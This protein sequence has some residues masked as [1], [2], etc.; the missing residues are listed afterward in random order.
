MSE[1]APHPTTPHDHARALGALGLRVLPIKPG[2]KRP[3]MSSWQHAA[4][5]DADKIDNWY[6]GLYRDA[7]VGIALG[8]QPNGLY[9]FAI[10][11]DTHDPAHNGWDALADLEEEHGELPATWRSL[12]GADGA[13]LIFAAPAGVTVRN[14]QASGNRIAPGIDVRGDGGQIVV[15][16]TVHP[17]TQRTYEWEA[18]HAPWERDVARAPRWL[19]ELVREPDPEPVQVP[20]SSL[21]RDDSLFDAHRADWDWHAELARRG[22]QLTI[23]QPR[24]VDSHWTRPGKDPRQ[25]NSGV[26]HEPDGPFVIFT[27]EIPNGWRDA[28]KRSRDGSAYSFGPFGFYA[29]TEH[30]G[31]RSE[32]AR[33]LADRYGAP[34]VDL[35]AL[36]AAERHTEADPGTVEDRDAYDSQ[37]L[38]M[39]IDWPTF[40]STDHTAEEWL[41]E[42]V[43]P[44]R[45]G[46]V[47]WAKGGTGKSLVL[48]RMVLDLVRRGVRVLYLDYEMTPDD[49]HDRLEEMGVENPAELDGL[50]YAQ[51]PSLPGFDTPEG[52]KAVTR[53]ASLVDA[54][55]V[56]IDTFARAVEGEE[57][58]SDTVRDFYRMTGLH[59]K[60]A[61][62][63]FIRADHAGKDESKGQRGS[64][65]KND[66]V[67]LVWQL[68]VADGG[69]TLIRGK[70]R[71]GWVPESVHLERHDAPYR[72]EVKGGKSY[73]PGASDCAKVLDEVGV[74]LDMGYRKASEMV[75]AA[76][77]PKPVRAVLRSALK[78]RRERS[79]TMHFVGD[80]V[81]TESEKGAPSKSRRTPGAPSD[82]APDGAPSENQV[83]DQVRGCAEGS[84]AHSAHLADAGTAQCASYQEA[85][86]SER[87]PETPDPDPNNLF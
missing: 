25:G 87:D 21:P 69:Y 17:N 12:T 49:L 80:L 59:L 20:E 76:G 81:A 82:G 41:W 47:L 11:V 13:H 7:G 15:A 54:D 42:P 75:V 18:D 40:W 44:A 32:A 73:E 19:L 74:P 9:L 29:A 85:H 4:T 33:T 53:F 43:I 70:C 83:K 77:H 30:D 22:W 2:H 61:G 72:I 37:L 65:A 71:M 52:G 27:T 3:P 51:L 6:R 39:L 8:P 55:L 57:N 5:D 66:D 84:T 14:Q 26:L 68:K 46:M 10:D 78:Y 64:S 28:G 31:D 48:L 38:G 16:P 56:V 34:D 45:R 86:A 79:S 35:G 58:D 50:H 62:R 36:V 24:G 67:D 60:A 1:P 23:P 63:A